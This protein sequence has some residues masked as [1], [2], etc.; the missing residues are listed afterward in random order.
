MSSALPCNRHESRTRRAAGPR[1]WSSSKLGVGCGPVGLAA[2]A[3]ASG[4]HVVGG[5]VCG[6]PGLWLVTKS[7]ER[8][9]WLPQSNW[10]CLGWWLR[11]SLGPGGGSGAEPLTSARCALQE[12]EAGLG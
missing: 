11:I 10:P 4:G 9:H 12:G 1:A 3:T 2:A 7:P 8:S 5:S 6:R